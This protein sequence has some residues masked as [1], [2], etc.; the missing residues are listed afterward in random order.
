MSQIISTIRNRTIARRA[1]E[2]GFT[3]AEAL[4]Y[5]TLVAL[6][7]GALTM[8]I[9]TTI[10]AY[11][12]VSIDGMLEDNARLIIRALENEARYA[13]S[14]YT[15][16]SVFASHPGQ[17]SLQTSLNVPEGE[18]LTYVDY[19]FDNGKLYIKREESATR[20]ITSDSVSVSSFIVFQ[21]STSS[22]KV[23]FSLAPRLQK[24]K[25]SGGKTY[26]ATMSLRGK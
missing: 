26:T 8:L 19:Y 15:P 10:D 23:N 18:I 24:E 14:V 25:L 4:V 17:L 11:R 3:L 2:S 21:L 22:V 16:T 13:S 20:T 1:K 6:M 12:R 7:V 5:A 9:I